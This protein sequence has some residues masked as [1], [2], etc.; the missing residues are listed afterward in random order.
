M[1]PAT[2]ELFAVDSTM[3]Q[4]QQRLLA[5]AVTMEQKKAAGQ[6]VQWFWSFSEEN[7]PH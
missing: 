3:Q 4:Q 6:V 5:A 7:A 2:E 1:G